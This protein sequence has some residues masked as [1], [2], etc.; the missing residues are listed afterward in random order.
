MTYSERLGVDLKD[1][2]ER[3]SRG[4]LSR[5]KNAKARVRQQIFNFVGFE[6]LP[7]MEPE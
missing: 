4:E 2:L 6:G 7:E 5:S 1:K 3:V